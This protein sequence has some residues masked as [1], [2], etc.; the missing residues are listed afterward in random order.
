MKQVW[1][2]LSRKQALRKIGLWG[3]LFFLTKGLVWLALAWWGW[4][5]LG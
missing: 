1:Y 2:R 4:K 3:F 5:R